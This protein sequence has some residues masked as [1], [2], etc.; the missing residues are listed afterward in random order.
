MIAELKIGLFWTGKAATL[1]FELYRVNIEKGMYGNADHFH[2]MWQEAE[3]AANA[4]KACI[5]ENEKG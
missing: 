5:E 3:K 1:A 4:I 2:K